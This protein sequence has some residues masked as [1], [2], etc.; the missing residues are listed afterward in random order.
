M[1]LNTAHNYSEAFE[2][3]PFEPGPDFDEDRFSPLPGDELRSS[4]KPIALHWHRDADPNAERSWFVR[5]LLS[6]TGKGLLSGQW[7]SAKTF[8][9]LDLCG[10]AMTGEAFAGRRVLRRGGVLFIAP[11]GAYEIPIRLKGLVSGKLA[12]VAMARAASGEEA[13]DPNDLPFAWIEECPRLV[14]R[15]A[16]E[17]L[18]LTADVAVAELRERYDLPLVLIIVDTVAAG[19]GFDDENSAAETQKVMNA[20]ERL[21]KHTGAFVLGVDHFGKMIE[22]GTR[23]SS[24]KEAAADTV[25]A[26]LASRDEAGNVRNTRMAVRKVRGARTGMETPYSLDVVQ[27]GDDRWGEPITT[28]CITWQTSR[29]AEAATEAAKS[30]WPTSLKVFQA[31]MGNT[32]AEHSRKIFPFGNEGPQVSAVAQEHVRDEFAAS[33]PADGETPA[34]RTEAKKKAFQRAVRTAQAKGLISVRDMLGV[35]HFWFLTDE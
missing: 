33:Y 22:T 31:A 34:Q 7:G 8:I 32:L 26:A 15:D 13:V 5:D 1:A 19:A 23:G 21:S 11:E 6:T 28:C 3:R 17:T 29:L 12:G 18:I 9:A 2:R 35:P 25:L 27:I 20:L 24:A 14:D 16:A 30:R 10:S 4:R